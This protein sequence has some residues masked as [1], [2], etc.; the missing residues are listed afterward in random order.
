MIRNRKKKN[1]LYTLYILNT[2]QSISICNVNKA[3]FKDA[4]FTFLNLMIM[5][6][7]NTWGDFSKGVKSK[8]YTDKIK[9]VILPVII[10]G[11]R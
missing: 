6:V 3:R 9:K 7:A 4:I 5:G 8:L 2:Y 1:V 10:I 11:I